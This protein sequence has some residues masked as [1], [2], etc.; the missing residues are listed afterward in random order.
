MAKFHIKLKLQGLEL[1]VD[2]TRED[3]PVIREALT[4]QIAG[5]L[6][7]GTEIAGGAVIPATASANGSTPAAEAAKRA[8]RRR[9]GSRNGGTGAGDSK[10][11]TIEWRHD[12][13][14]YG[15]P[16]QTW[17]NADKAMWL[18]YVAN[19]E[20]K[21]A[22]MS[23]PQM[24]ATFLKQFRSAG[25]LQ[26][27]NLGRDLSKFKT[28]QNGKPPLVSED[29]TKNPPKWFLT[30]SGKKHAQDLVAQALGQHAS[31]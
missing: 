7:P 23:R 1:E 14:K 6:Q 20:S 24:L 22:E 12:T 16:Q 21:A 2:G 29:A 4:Q 13:S 31:A 19:E 28:A 27:N 26:A 3:L 11:A 25:P 10:E 17:T 8:T 5:V 15:S 30:D 9:S 18:L